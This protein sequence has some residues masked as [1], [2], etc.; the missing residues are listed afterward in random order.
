MSPT[1]KLIVFALLGSVIGVA[2]YQYHQN[3]VNT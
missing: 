3:S 2:V 1:I